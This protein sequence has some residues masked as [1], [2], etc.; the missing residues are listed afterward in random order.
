MFIS[1]F[2]FA[3]IAF[4]I[5]SNIFDKFWQWLA[6]GIAVFLA[7]YFMIKSG[8][9]APYVIMLVLLVAIMIILFIKKRFS[10]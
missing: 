4:I 5:A 1:S 3:W 8:F 9:A 6:T 2:A 7:T 10:K